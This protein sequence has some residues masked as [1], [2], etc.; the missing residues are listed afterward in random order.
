MENTAQKHIEAVKE[1]RKRENYGRTSE[2]D[3]MSETKE[4]IEK[5]KIG[6]KF[7]C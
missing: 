7:N 6:Y 5:V 2:I 1:V 3:V 4:G